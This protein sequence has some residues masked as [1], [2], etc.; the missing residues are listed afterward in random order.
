M[1]SQLDKLKARFGDQGLLDR[2]S[3]DVLH[4]KLLQA[5]LDAA[6]GSRKLAE[7]APPP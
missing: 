2:A 6:N 1:V 7:I 5:M 4:P 3:H